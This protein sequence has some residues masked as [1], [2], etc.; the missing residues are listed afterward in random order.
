MLCGCAQYTSRAAQLYKAALEKDL[1][2]V[3]ANAMACPTSPTAAQAAKQ[4]LDLLADS[5]RR[6]A[7]TPPPPPPFTLLYQML[8][9]FVH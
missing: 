1:E 4:G 7:R 9:C 6:P 3:K 8:G 2:K 5:V